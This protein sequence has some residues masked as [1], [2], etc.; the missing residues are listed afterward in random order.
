[1]RYYNVDVLPG[2]NEIYVATLNTKLTNSDL[3]FYSDHIDGPYFFFPFSVVYRVLVGLSENKQIESI[4]PLLPS[5]FTLSRNEAYGFDFN[6]EVHRIQSIPGVTNTQHRITLKLHYCVYPR[7]LRPLGLLHGWLT[8]KYDIFARGLFLKTITPTNLVEKFLARVVLLC[9]YVYHKVEVYVGLSNL[10]YLFSVTVCSYF[11]GPSFWLV[12]TSFRHYFMYL[13]TYYYRTNISYGRFKQDCLLYKGLAFCNLAYFYWLDLHY[14]LL[15]LVL[16]LFGFG[17]ASLATIVLGI[18]RTYFG[19]ELGLYKP[20]W[21]N[22]FPYGYIPH[23]MILGG[24]I[25]LIGIHQVIGP[26]IPFLVPFHLV[27]YFTH[28]LQEHYQIYHREGPKMVELAIPI[29]LKS[30]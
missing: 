9:T 3:V 6:R 21:I 5:R 11:V 29:K 2:M 20:K 17:L 23:P 28:M 14:N 18:D 12:C 1:M 16:M 27:L 26:R 22:Q 30:L 10:L 4:F 15:S 7:C 19:S 8:T 25:G 24:M 13:G